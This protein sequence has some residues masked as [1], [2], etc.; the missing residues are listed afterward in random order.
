M[1]DGFDEMFNEGLFRAGLHNSTASRP[2]KWPKSTSEMGRHTSYTEQ[3]RD[4]GEY[5][6]GMFQAGLHNTRQ[7][8][9]DK[10]PSSVSEMRRH[11]SYASQG[12]GPGEAEAAHQSYTAARAA[13][14]GRWVYIPAREGYVWVP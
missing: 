8:R 6:E 11:T 9:P 14:R 5:N 3:T 2:T 12:M 4:P 13:G 1:S 7:S 10:W